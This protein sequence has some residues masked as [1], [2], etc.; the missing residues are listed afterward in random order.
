MIKKN[1]WALAL[2]ALPMMPVWAP[3]ESTADPAATENA[4]ASADMTKPA[5]AIA[6]RFYVSPTFDYSLA[7]TTGI[8]TMASA[9]ASLSASRL[10]TVSIWNYRRCT[11]TMAPSR[12]REMSS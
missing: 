7:E 4:A 6:N 1:T 12:A 10:P 5:S 9:D 3:I 11:L 2:L 8:R